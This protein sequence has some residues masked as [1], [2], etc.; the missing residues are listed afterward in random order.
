[1]RR[2]DRGRIHRGSSDG[3][4]RDEGTGG[5]DVKARD[6]DAGGDKGDGAAAR[7]RDED[8]VEAS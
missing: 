8:K 1:M 5:D 4:A 3:E 2:G 6:K 7:A